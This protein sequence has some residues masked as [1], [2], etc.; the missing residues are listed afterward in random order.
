VPVQ[1][2]AE[3]ALRFG[4]DLRAKPIQDTH[5]VL[6]FEIGIERMGEN[7]ME[8]FALMVIHGLA[9]LP[10]SG[11]LTLAPFPSEAAGKRYAANLIPDN[12]IVE[13]FHKTARPTFLP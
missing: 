5:Y 4:V 7:R 2:D 3:P 10:A 1:R 12:G 11:F 9:S 6:Y 13:R 8:N